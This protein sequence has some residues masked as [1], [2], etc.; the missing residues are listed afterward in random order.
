MHEHRPLCCVM[1]SCD[2]AVRDREREKK[3]DWEKKKIGQQNI[4]ESN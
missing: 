4:G 2:I 1:Q 3:E